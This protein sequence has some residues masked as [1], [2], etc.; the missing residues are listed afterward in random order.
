MQLLFRTENAHRLPG[1]QFLPFA[2]S[3]ADPMFFQTAAGSYFLPQTLLR[4]ETA[5]RSTARKY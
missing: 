5:V 2:A 4:S 1:S 3:P